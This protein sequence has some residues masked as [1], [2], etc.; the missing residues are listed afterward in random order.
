MK[1]MRYFYSILFLKDN[2]IINSQTILK[3]PFENIHYHNRLLS[4]IVKMSLG[5]LPSRWS[6]LDPFSGKGDVEPVCQEQVRF[7]SLKTITYLAKN[8]SG[9]FFIK[10]SK[11]DSHIFVLKIN[12]KKNINWK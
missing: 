12:K 8:L 3:L 11:Y 1:T 6:L 4:S 10:I 7:F 2:V 9:P 5:I